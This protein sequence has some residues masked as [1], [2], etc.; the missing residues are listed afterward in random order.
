ML[1]VKNARYICSF[2][3]VSKVRQTTGLRDLNGECSLSPYLLWEGLTRE[4]VERADK[5]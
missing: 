3:V 5:K 2:R 4:T 1:K